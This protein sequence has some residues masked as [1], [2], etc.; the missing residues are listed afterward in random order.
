M[1][2]PLLIALVTV[3]LLVG[4]S[5]VIMNSA[6]KNSHHGWCAP[7]SDIRHRLEPRTTTLEAGE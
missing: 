1:K 2:A 3:V 4:S 7:M 5:L 6:C